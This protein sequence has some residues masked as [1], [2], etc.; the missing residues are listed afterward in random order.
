MRRS[1][2]RMVGRVGGLLLALLTLLP[3]IAS[4]HQHPSNE[5]SSPESCPVCVAKASS[6]ATAAPGVPSLAPALRSVAVVPASFA[7]PGYA[8]QPFR[9]GRAPPLSSPI[10]RA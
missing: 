8:D 1:W 2:G 10:H 6:P 3:V 4:S 7:A 5:T 9:S